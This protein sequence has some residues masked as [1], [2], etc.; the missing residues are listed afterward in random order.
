MGQHMSPSK[1]KWPFPWVLDLHWTI[2]VSRSVHPFLYNTVMCPTPTRTHIPAETTLSAACGAAIIKIMDHDKLINTSANIRLH[3]Q[4]AVSYTSCFPLRLEQVVTFPYLLTEDGECTTEFRT[5]LKRGQAIGA[6]LQKI[7]KS[8]SI[9]IS[10][11][12]RLNESL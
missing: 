4:I 6:S 11:K 8:H 9:P 1:V 10:T 2:R 12:I 5:R 3:K 7:W